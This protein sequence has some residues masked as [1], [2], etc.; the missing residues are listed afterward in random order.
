MPS[1][2]EPGAPYMRGIPMT[3]KQSRKLALAACQAM[4]RA[5]PHAYS[6]HFTQAGHFVVEDAHGRLAGKLYTPAEFMD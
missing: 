5:L 4:G 6:S 1:G 2:I 3:E